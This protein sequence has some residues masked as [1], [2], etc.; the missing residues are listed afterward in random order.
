VYE[1]YA[2]LLSGDDDDFA[3]EV[4]DECVGGERLCGDCKEQAAVL[5]EEFLA[6]HQEKRREVEERLDDLDLEIESPR[7]RVAGEA[8]EGDEPHEANGEDD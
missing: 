1:L 6:D 5:M 8:V 7:R 2:Y 3:K 4:Y